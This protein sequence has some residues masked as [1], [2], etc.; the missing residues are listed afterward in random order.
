MVNK[1]ISALKHILFRQ[2]KLGEGG[3]TAER[4]RRAGGKKSAF[5]RAPP[6]N[7]HSKQRRHFTDVK[8]VSW[9]LIGKL[10]VCQGAC[11]SSAHPGTHM[12]FSESV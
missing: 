11:V 2:K 8:N 5:W 3:G 10:Y 1:Q 9:I 4:G 7:T 6:L 12:V